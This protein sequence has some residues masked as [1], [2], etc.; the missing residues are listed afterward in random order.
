MKWKVS[1]RLGD[2]G[3]SGIAGDRRIQIRQG[4]ALITA[5]CNEDGSR[6]G[7]S[8]NQE[9]HQISRNPRVLPP[10]LLIYLQ[11]PRERVHVLLCRR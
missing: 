1:R 3:D 9:I 11:L 4:G 5:V 2:L 10:W 7:F 6:R 8:S